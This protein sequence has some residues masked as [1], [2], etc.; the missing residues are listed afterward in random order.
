MTAVAKP[1]GATPD[2]FVRDIRDADWGRKEMA[3]A[4]TEMP[5]L[6]AIRKEFGAVLPLRG[7]R[8]EVTEGRSTVL[9]TVT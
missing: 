8:I 5:G 2:Y 7:A 9:V 3:I 4:E 1:A 6:M